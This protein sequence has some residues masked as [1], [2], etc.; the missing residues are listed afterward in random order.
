MH[1]TS[2]L[3]GIQQDKKAML[4]AA[5]FAT[6]FTNP[7]I[8]ELEGTGQQETIPSLAASSSKHPAP[9]PLPTAAARALPA[10]L[11][12]Q[13]LILAISPSCFSD[14]YANPHTNGS[15]QNP[16]KPGRYLSIWVVFNVGAS[17]D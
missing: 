7:V 8:L 11:P 13:L 2:G 14:L 16:A 5:F 6:L 10:L 9:K 4:E 3:G 17:L 1:Y 12:A 15:Q